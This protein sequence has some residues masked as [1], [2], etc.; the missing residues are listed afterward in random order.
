MTKTLL[1]SH[2]L[3]VCLWGCQ[4]NGAH[5]V[6]FHFLSSRDST[7]GFRLGTTWFYL[8]SHLTSPRQSFWWAQRHRHLAVKSGVSWVWPAFHP[9]VSHFIRS[10][11]SHPMMPRNSFFEGLVL[12][13][14]IHSLTLFSLFVQLPPLILEW[15]V[16]LHKSEWYCFC[17]LT[18][19]IAW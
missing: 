2:W 7:Q 6:F 1:L 4:H 17:K 10:C 19:S 12:L 11:I 3:C 15:L 13:A 18:C 5:L 9:Q 16:V 14:W 8:R